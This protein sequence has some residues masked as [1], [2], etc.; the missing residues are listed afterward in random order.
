MTQLEKFFDVRVEP[1]HREV[2]FD[3]GGFWSTEEIKEVLHKLSV[4]AMTFISKGQTFH[5]LGDMEKLVPQSRETAAAIRDNLMQGKANGLRRVAIISPPVLMKMQYQR[6]ADGMPVEFFD[7]AL[8][9]K[10]W[11]RKQPPEA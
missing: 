2:Q 3:I 7:T 10:A 1:T 6:I 4:A 9:A 5:G 8:E 11:L